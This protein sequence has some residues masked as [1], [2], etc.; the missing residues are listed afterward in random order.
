MDSNSL[1]VLVGVAT[2]GRRP[3]PAVASPLVLATVLAPEPAPAPAPAPEL[4]LRGCLDAAN[5]GFSVYCTFVVVVTAA[6]A[7]EDGPPMDTSAS[8]AAG[9]LAAEVVDAACERDAC[10][11]GLVVVVAVLWLPG[12]R[13]WPRLNSNATALSTL[14]RE[15]S[16][17]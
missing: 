2:E 1:A 5:I 4:A 10:S 9:A 14:P 6:D 7:A 16:S 11:L 8:A 13:T 15:D 12:G 17:S 3:W